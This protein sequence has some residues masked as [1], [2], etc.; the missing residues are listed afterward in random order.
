MIFKDIKLFSQNVQKNSLIIKTILEVKSNFDIIFIQ[1][2]SWATIYSIPSSMNCERDIMVGIVNHPNWLTFARTSINKN[3]GSRV[4][5]YI[6]IRLSS[7]CFSLCKDIID[8][9][10]I[11]LVLFFNNNDIFWLM[12][13]YSDSSH[14]ALKYLK[15]TKA[16]IQNLLIMTSDF[17]I[18]DR[19]WDPFFPHYLFISNDLLIIADSFNLNLLIPINQVPTRYSD[20][21]NDSNL[22]IDLMFL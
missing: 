16:N 12:N 9:R 20:N 1:E 22:V 4:A 11:L 6:N 15:D 2:P 17:N 18:R 21:I 10:D 3:K 7:F 14:L 8:H 19:L 13:I 5:I